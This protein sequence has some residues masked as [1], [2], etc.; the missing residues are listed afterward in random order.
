M[1]SPSAAIPSK[2][3]SA[4]G[5]LQAAK[6]R[7][8]KAAAELHSATT[9]LAILAGAAAAEVRPPVLLSDNR[10]SYRVSEV[11]AMLGVSRDQV[12]KEIREGRLTSRHMGG[13]TLIRRADLESYLDRLV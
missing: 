8:Q 6:D 9:E 4:Q 11:A 3:D 7:V 13:V 2:P 5:K 10:M 12:E 1:K